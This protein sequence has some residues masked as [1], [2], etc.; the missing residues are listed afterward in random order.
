MI[1]GET[2]RAE[3]GRREEIAAIGSR[4]REAI[5]DLF[6]AGRNVQYDANTNTVS[7]AGGPV[8]RP[9]NSSRERSGVRR[10]KAGGAMEFE[11]GAI[12]E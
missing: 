9:R 11:F 5:P 7:A 4:L 8:R 1:D 6:N 3:I 12:R 2:E 10:A